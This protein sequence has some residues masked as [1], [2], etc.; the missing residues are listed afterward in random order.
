M[1]RYENVELLV[2]TTAEIQGRRA[3]F[4]KNEVVINSDT[5]ELRAGPGR[6]PEMEVLIAP[7]SSMV[8][9]VNGASG[10]VKAAPP[11]IVARSSEAGNPAHATGM[12]IPE[13]GQFVYILET[14]RLYVGDGRTTIAQLVAGTQYLVPKSDMR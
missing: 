8:R 7:T 4:G 6:W 14:G 13:S 12:L 10:S 2:M 11:T 9:D 1:R 3:R 5:K